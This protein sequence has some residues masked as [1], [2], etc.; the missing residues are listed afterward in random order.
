MSSLLLFKAGEHA[1]KPRFF[2]QD[3]GLG[4]DL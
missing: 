4:I 1:L 3:Q 2:K